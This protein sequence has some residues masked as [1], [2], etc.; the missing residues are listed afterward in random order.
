MNV[1]RSSRN[2][3][4][5]ACRGRSHSATE[6]FTFNQV[7]PH[8][9]QSIVLD[10]FRINLFPYSLKRILISW[11]RFHSRLQ[12][13]TARSTRHRPHQFTD[14]NPFEAPLLKR[15]L[16]KKSPRATSSH[17]KDIR[18]ESPAFFALRCCNQDESG[19]WLYQS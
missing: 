8:H 9:E 7:K 13:A 17:G 14:T 12:V 5:I 4:V 6:R 1:R 3:G 11:A 15:M 18:A 2:F 10:F 16:G 19:L